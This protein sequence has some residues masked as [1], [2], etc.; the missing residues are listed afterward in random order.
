VS[1]HSVPEKQRSLGLTLHARA[2]KPG[3]AATQS[4]PQGA[5]SRPVFLTRAWSRYR[6][7][8]QV[9]PA[10][11]RKVGGAG[12]NSDAET[13]WRAV[14]DDPDSGGGQELRQRSP[15]LCDDSDPS[16]RN[17]L[18][19][20]T[21]KNRLEKLCEPVEP[22]ESCAT[23]CMYARRRSQMHCL[24]H[25]Q[26]RSRTGSHMLACSVRDVQLRRKA[27]EQKGSDGTSPYRSVV[28]KCC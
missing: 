12:G 1:A 27:G 10:P 18:L 11:R 26:T 4:Q 8:P 13:G 9:A 14:G 17:V 25:V 20:A 2:R 15:K 21:V 19:H 16:R 6:T 5:C 23:P 24:A 28:R 22:P 7:A 3:A